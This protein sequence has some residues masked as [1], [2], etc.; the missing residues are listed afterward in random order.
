MSGSFKYQKFRDPSFPVYCS[1]REGSGVLVKPHYHPAAELNL[2]TAGEVLAYVNTEQILLEQGDFLYVPPY[3]I[4]SAVSQAPQAQLQGIVYDYSLIPDA[5]CATSLQA[6]SRDKLTGL[7]IKPSD[8][9]YEQIRTVFLQ[10]TGFYRQPS[11]TCQLE[12]LG[13]LFQLT[14]LLLRHYQISQDASALVNRLQPAID[15]IRANYAQNITVSQLSSLIHVCDDH[16]IRL[17]K[18]ATN[19]TPT[20]YLLDVRLEAAMKLLV[21]TD[22][23]ATEI[24][25][26]CGFSNSCYMAR[27]F[28]NRLRKT[29]M[30]YR[31][32]KL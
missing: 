26:R 28:K 17:F 11:S 27:V 18:A 31:K 13:S 4:H 9:L 15:Y 14:A 3:C 23:S 24:A 8:G 12:M 16:L 6:L 2:I 29:P 5:M 32:T 1:L 20:G 10:G 30:Q 25:G 19:K 22:L 7:V 21:E